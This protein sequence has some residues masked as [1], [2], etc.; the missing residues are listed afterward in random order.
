MGPGFGATEVMCQVIGLDFRL[1]FEEGAIS[2]P[3]HRSDV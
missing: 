3:D 1:E 2:G